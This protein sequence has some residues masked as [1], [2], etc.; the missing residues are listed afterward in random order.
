MPGEAGAARRERSRLP[1]PQPSAR[2]VSS[3]GGIH[4]AQRRGHR[5]IDQRVIGAGDHQQ[6]AR[7]ILQGGAQ[8]D[9]GIAG[10]EGRDGERHGHQHGPEPPRRQPR[11]LHEPGRRGAD[12]RGGSSRRRDGD[13]QGM[14]QQFADQRAEQQMAGRLPA[15]AAGLHGGD[16]KRQQHQQDREASGGEQPGRRAGARDAER[17]PTD[18]QAGR[19]MIAHSRPASCS[20]FADIAVVAQL[21]DVQ[22]GR[23]KLVEGL[24]QRIGR[25]AGTQRIFE[26]DVALGEQVLGP[27]ADEI[28]Q[29]VLG[30]GGIGRRSSAPPAPETLTSAPTSPWPK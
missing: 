5:Q 24:Q 7:E 18:A 17:R 19:R 3:S 4:A 8:R 16:A 2:A 26:I 27:L 11:P 25:H 29:E 13:G 15:D 9:P 28:G 30:G 20:S 10:D 12:D 23:L 6:G 22:G 14:E 1:G 21:G